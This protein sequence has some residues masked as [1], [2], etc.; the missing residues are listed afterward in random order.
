ANGSFT[1]NVAGGT[2]P[3]TYTWSAGGVPSASVLS[4]AVAGNYTV[5]VGYG[6]SANCTVTQTLNLPN[7]TTI[8]IISTT[9]PNVCFGN[10]AGS[11]SIVNTSGGVPPFAYSWS[12]GQTGASA[13]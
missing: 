13:I 4:N 12:N 6:G 9:N 11:V 3:Y 10:N 1:L 7:A 2:L 5:T 8:S